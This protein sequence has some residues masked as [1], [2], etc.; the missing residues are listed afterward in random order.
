VCAELRVL[1]ALRNA[2]TCAGS[3]AYVHAR[4]A[5]PPPVDDGWGLPE[6]PHALHAGEVAA[7]GAV[8]VGDSSVCSTQRNSL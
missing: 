7:A 3:I 1:G 6:V 4:I 2:R 5:L 8:G